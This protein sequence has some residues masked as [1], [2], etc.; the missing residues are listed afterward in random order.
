MTPFLRQWND[1]VSLVLALLSKAHLILS[2]IGC[3]KVLL[4]KMSTMLHRL[5]NTIIYPASGYL[6]LEA[7]ARRRPL[8]GKHYALQNNAYL[9]KTWHF[10]I[11]EY[12]YIQELN[13]NTGHEKKV[14]CHLLPVKC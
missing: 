9:R 13:L 4:Q 12:A 8:S 6:C 7:Q 10:S 5:S 1:L 3:K 11:S 14:F 2:W